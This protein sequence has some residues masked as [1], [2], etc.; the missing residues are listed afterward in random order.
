MNSEHGKN[1]KV[2]SFSGST[3]NDMYFY[4]YPLL[5]KCPKY[6]LLHVGTNDCVTRAS[7]KVLDD[8]LLLKRHIEINVP[9]INVIFSQPIMRCDNDA[10]ACLRVS[11]LITKLDQLRLP[12]MVNRNVIRKHIGKKG[13]H[14]NG[15]GTARCAMNIISLI[16]G[17]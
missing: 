9:G 10:L 17:L 3:I 2:R 5:K 12:L 8:L 1:V 7:D 6:L 11:K 13:L 14:L 15:Y 16:K 4:L